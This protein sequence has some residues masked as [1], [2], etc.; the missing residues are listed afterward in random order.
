MTL[1][2]KSI[3]SLIIHDAQIEMNCRRLLTYPVYW[4]LANPARV[5]CFSPVLGAF[6]G[7]NLDFERPLFK[8]ASNGV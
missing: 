6:E 7:L 5:D 3:R 8:P 4:N 1:T 2:N